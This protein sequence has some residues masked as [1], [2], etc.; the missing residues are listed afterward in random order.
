MAVISIFFGRARRKV[1]LRHLGVLTEHFCVLCSLKLAGKGG[2]T[3]PP[4]T[5]LKPSILLVAMVLVPFR[6]HVSAI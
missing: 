2:A 1:T 3:A 5:K 6:P 4:Y